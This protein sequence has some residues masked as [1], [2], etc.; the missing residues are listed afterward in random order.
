MTLLQAKKN[1]VHEG[2]HVSNR[3][4]AHLNHGYVQRLLSIK[5]L[6]QVLIQILENHSEAIVRVN[7]IIQT[8]SDTN[9]AGPTEQYWDGGVPSA[10]QFHESPYW[11]FLLLSS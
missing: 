1:L 10:V 9:R 3:S 5:E 6:A 7:N 11:E 8:R 4:R 2:L